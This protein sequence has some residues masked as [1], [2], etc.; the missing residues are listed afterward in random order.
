MGRKSGA[1]RREICP[2]AV[3]QR[4][5]EAVDMREPAIELD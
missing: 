2:N 5:E 1:Q 4:V 3:Q